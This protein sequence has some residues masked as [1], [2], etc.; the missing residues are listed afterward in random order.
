MRVCVYICA[1]AKCL[2]SC[3]HFGS[4]PRSK[5]SAFF[6]HPPTQMQ[7]REENLLEGLRPKHA[8]RA[9][10]SQTSRRDAIKRKQ[11]RLTKRCCVPE[12]PP[13]YQKKPPK[14]MIVE[15][16][17]CVLCPRGCRSRCELFRRGSSL[18]RGPPCKAAV[19][20]RRSEVV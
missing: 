7:G 1:C 20:T 18:P 9:H 14:R 12:R 8:H 17:Q 19:G 15:A 6:S 16:H 5:V 4:S 3:V 13:P 10:K 2:F 11:R